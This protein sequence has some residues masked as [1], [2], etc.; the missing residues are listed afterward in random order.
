MSFF[1]TTELSDPE[2]ES[3]NLR[4]ITVKSKNLKG[5]G[6]ICVFVPKGN[7]DTNLPITILLHGVYGSAWSWSLSGGVHVTAQK[8]IDEGRI[9]PM[10]IA[11]PSDGLWGDGSGYTQ[12]NGLDFE[13]WIVEDVIT[14][15]KELIPQAKN[16]NKNF[17]SGLSMGG[18]GALRI[19]AKY[20][21]IFNAFSGLSS[22]TNLN[23]MPQFVEEKLD[24][25]RVS[26]T[27]E[28]SVIETILTHKDN[29]S[30]FRFDCG[31]KDP[32]IAYNRT[33]EQVLKQNNIPHQYDEFEGQHEWP[34]WKKHIV[35]TL[36]FFNKQLD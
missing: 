35:E 7:T 34:Y 12:H 8:L 26:S 10:I 1:R 16:S 22:I 2:F 3:N 18:F 33:L 14:A 32:L 4:F 29:L 13:K 11:M 6:D 28:E 20:S 24:A 17:L 36:L 27:D 30:P 19:G 21:A 5:R 23:Q 25:Y 9:K 31:K 15:V